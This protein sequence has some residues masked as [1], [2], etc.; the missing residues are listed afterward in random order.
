MSVLSQFSGSGQR[1][2][3][4]LVNKYAD[5]GF[6]CA[7]V[8][9]STNGANAKQVYSGAMTAATL[10]TILSVTGAGSIDYLSVRGMDIT[11]R[12]LRMKITI[13]GV[14]VLDST[15]AATADASSN[16]AVYIGV[17]DGSGATWP[18]AYEPTLFNAS[19]LVEV[20]SSLSETDKFLIGYKY[21][22]F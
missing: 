5:S 18:A 10:K 11:S 6:V 16:G 9:L 13:D 15:S 1:P 17:G 12:T 2:P 19:L 14:V 20:A 22:T 7:R 8:D 3:K 4:V 21:R